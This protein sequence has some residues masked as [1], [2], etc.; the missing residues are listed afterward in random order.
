M[1]VFD[2]ID[3]HRLARGKGPGRELQLG[4][5][6]YIQRPVEFDSFRQAVKQL[7]L[8]WLAVNEP[9]PALAFQP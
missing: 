5:N 7:G 1:R 4:V 2:Q 6:G 8:Y 3:S 9:P